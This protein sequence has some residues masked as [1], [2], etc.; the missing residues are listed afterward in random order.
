MEPTLLK[1]ITDELNETIRGGIISKIHQ[2]TDKTVIFK[3]FIRGREHRLLISSEA[4]A[5]RAHLTLKRYPNPE[6]PLRFCAFLRSHISNA[7]IERVEVVEGER[8]AKILLKKRNSDGESESLTL[9]AELTGK[10]ANIILIDSKHVVMDAL[11]YFA[12]ESLRAVSPGLE[13]KPLTN[14]SNKSASKGSPIE[15]NKET[16]NESAD[17]F[18]SLGIEERER[19]KRENDLRRVVKKV[20]KRLTRKV[21]NL[22]ADIKKPG[23]MSKTLCRQ[24]C[25][26]RT[27]KS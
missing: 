14:N 24:N 10:S 8:I 12:P 3:I 15:K 17:S 7:L 23:Q 11:K 21:K 20:E 16:W 26:L 2:P 6:R 25:C 9:V 5:P 27:L 13:L 4:A 1:K 22:E 19:T 18:Y